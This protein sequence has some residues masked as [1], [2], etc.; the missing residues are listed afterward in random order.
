MRSKQIAVTY[1][2][3]K[4]KNPAIIFLDLNLFRSILPWAKDSARELFATQKPKMFL[5]QYIDDVAPIVDT[6]LSNR[7]YKMYNRALKTQN[8]LFT[9]LRSSEQTI[10]WI[11]DRWINTFINLTTNRNYKDYI[12]ITKIK[13]PYSDIAYINNDNGEVLYFLVPQSF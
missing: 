3:P 12:D 2:A 7:A 10:A 8:K 5:V 6:Y 13:I 4:I 9:N 11:I 1:L